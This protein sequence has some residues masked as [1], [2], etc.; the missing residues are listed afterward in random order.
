LVL[1]GLIAATGKVQFVIIDEIQ[2]NPDLLDIV[3][4]LMVE[5]KIKFI[6]KGSSARK[7]GRGH[8]NFHGGRAFCF[9]CFPLTHLE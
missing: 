5:Q 1:L 7:L 6:L 2:K 3:Q 8:A 4:R 9:D